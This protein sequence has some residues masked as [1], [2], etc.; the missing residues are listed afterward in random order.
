M[1]ILLSK[2]LDLIRIQHVDG[3]V[4]LREQQVRTLQR[5]KLRELELSIALGRYPLA[6]EEFLVLGEEVKREKKRF[7][8][9]AVV[10]ST[11]VGLFL[12]V[13]QELAQ[14]EFACLL[15][16]GLQRAPKFYQVV[17]VREREDQ[18]DRFELAVDEELGEIGLAFG[19]GL[20][21][22]LV[23]DCFVFYLLGQVEGFQVLGQL[24]KGH[25]AWPHFYLLASTGFERG[26]IDWSG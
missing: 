15:V 9:T 11:T 16:A 24:G 19:E 18:A 5:Q 21:V 2:R 8:G 6:E 25:L 20:L 17:A 22:S 4:L 13:V 12:D 3:F 10:N 7:K 26:G 23:Q 1:M 14:Q